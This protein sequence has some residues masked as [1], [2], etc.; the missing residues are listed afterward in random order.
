[1]RAG[2]VSVVI[3]S[4]NEAAQIEATLASLGLGPADEAVL[5]DGQSSDGTAARAQ[6]LQLQGLTVLETPPGRGAQLRAGVAASQAPWLLFLHADSRLEPGAL[7][8]L[9]HSSRE[10]GY[11]R[12]RFTRRTLGLR[13]LEG[14]IRLRACLRGPT[15]DQAIFVRRELL[16]RVGGVPEVPFLEDLVLARRLGAEARPRALPAEVRT[17]A[18]RYEERGLVA[19]TLRMWS[20][21]A[22]F[23]LGVSPSRLARS[24][25]SV[26]EGAG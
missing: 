18:R 16:E 2:A 13:V 14:G 4:L 20:I 12:L 7:D 10:W 22:A 21:R 17:S 23:A 25:P 6:A 8:A 15:G 1:V 24:Y 19:T 5:V 26:R 11:L 3:P 9:R